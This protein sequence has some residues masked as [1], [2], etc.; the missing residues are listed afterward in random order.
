MTDKNQPQIN[1][2]WKRICEIINEQKATNVSIDQIDY[3][4]NK[5]KKFPNTKEEE[6]FTI[7]EKGYEMSFKNDF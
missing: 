5:F 7:I 4:I 1:L 3:I 2:F 6:L